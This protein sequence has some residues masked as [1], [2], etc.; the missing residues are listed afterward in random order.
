MIYKIGEI[1]YNIGALQHHVTT[2]IG[3]FRGCRGAMCGAFFTANTLHRTFL[4]SCTPKVTPCYCLHL[5]SAKVIMMKEQFL[6]PLTWD[7][8][9]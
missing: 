3:Q 1:I 9:S 2:I 4:Y 7:N 6:P 8:N 5:T